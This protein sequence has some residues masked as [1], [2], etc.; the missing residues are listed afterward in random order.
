MRPQEEREGE[1]MPQ[2]LEG[3]QMGVIAA[4]AGCMCVIVCLLLAYVI[5]AVMT[6]MD[7]AGAAHTPCADD[8]NIWMFCLVAVI[9]MPVAGCVINLLSRMADSVGIVI[10]M[11]PSVVNLVIAVWGMLLWANMTDECMSFYDNDYGNLVLL[12][13]I[14]VVL[15]AVSAILLVCVVCVGVAALTA[16][17]SQG[18]GGTSRYEN[19]PD[20]VPE[21]GQS[22]LTEEYV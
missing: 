15:L 8:S 19:I 4:A 17:V 20:S 13:K 14:N 7:T 5:W 21:S 12:F 2:G 18:G 10:Q 3:M 9:V 6:I 16:A 11:I 1:G 22:S